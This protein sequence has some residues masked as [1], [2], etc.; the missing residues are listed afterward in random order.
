M[1]TVKQV[2][3]LA[4]VIGRVFTLELLAAV[5]SHSA[6]EL[7]EALE[8]LVAA[9]VLYRAD[10]PPQV[11]Y[12]FKHAL[13]Q[14]VAYQSLLKS[15][16]QQYHLRLARVLEERFPTIVQVQPELVAHHYTE[17]GQA[18]AAITHWLAAARRATQRSANLEAIA[19]LRRGLAL[20]DA[21]PDMAERR[22]QEH[23]LRLTM[24][25]PLI[26]AKGYASAEIEETCGQVVR[27]SEEIGDVSAIFPALS[28]RH[29][30]ESVTGQIDRAR[31]HAEELMRLAKRYPHS[32]G[33]AFA[34]RILGSATL[35]NGDSTSGRVLLEETLGKYDADRDRSSAFVYGHDHFATCASYLCLALWHQGEIARAEEYKERAIAHARSLSHMNTLCLAL[36]FTGGYFPGLCRDGEAVAR[37]AAEILALASEHKLPLWSAAGTVLMGHALAEQDRDRDGVAHMQAGLA[38]LQAINIRIFSPLFLAWQAA[39]QLRCG[40][41]REGMAAID[42]AF[43]IGKGGEHWMDAE[44][45]RLRGELILASSA[46]SPEKAEESLRAALGVAQAQRSKTLELRAAIGLARFYGTYA[47]GR[48]VL[49]PVL[50]WF[51]DDP[52]MRDVTEARLLLQSLS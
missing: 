32:D 2:A 33:E 6:R 42:E 52:D 48:E 16:R 41:I 49:A 26:A 13:L 47:A 43:E 3:Q 51:G 37:V 50:D 34:G 35:L 18:Q 38:G 40:Q 1:S 44:L 23:Q 17:A 9:E 10:R 24:I 46:D 21:L 25:A 5:A 14:D 11:V 30:S 4:A 31:R 15:S 28:G 29:A 45:H 20:L 8:K 39:A 22:R 12:E 7:G 36:A 19:Q 27:L